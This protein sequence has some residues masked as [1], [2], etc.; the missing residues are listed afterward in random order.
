M[1]EV[2]IQLPDHIARAL[3]N[4]PA[5]IG[6]HLVED[7]AIQGYRAG[8]LSHRDLCE[9]LHFDYWQTERFL[10]DH[11]VPLNYTAAELEADRATLQ[12]FVAVR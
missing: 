8:H 3:G 9:L 4:T 7:A 2:T 12:K 6:R 1:V 10:A 5:A 11:G